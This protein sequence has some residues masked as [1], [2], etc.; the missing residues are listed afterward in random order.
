MMVFVDV[1]NQQI[2]I[3][4]DDGTKKIP[5]QDAQVISQY[6]GNQT[7]S[8]I[9]NVIETNSI[10]IINLIRDITGQKEVVSSVQTN[11]NIYLHY[12]EDG[13]IL[14][15]DINIK[16]EGQSDC[17]LIDDEMKELIKQSSILQKLIKKEKVVVIG[18][19]ERQQL[20]IQHKQEIK[21]EQKKKEKVEESLS[22][23]IMDKPVSDWDGSIENNDHD[24]A[25][26]I[27][28][29]TRGAIENTGGVQTMS[30]L[31]GIL[32]GE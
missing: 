24:G 4:S 13:T 28:L 2:L 10:D 14:I 31:Q 23:I 27:D 3:Y 30:E 1:E 25:E 16:F 22:S 15:P 7:V 5:F 6:I 8:Y 21:K 18:D 19:Y 29:N 26:T 17:K 12:K 20:V 11:N 9:T 32:D